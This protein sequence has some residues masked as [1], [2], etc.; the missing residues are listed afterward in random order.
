MSENK[1]YSSF[2]SETEIKNLSVTALSNRPNE[3][4]GQYGKKGLTPE[5]LKA[6][7]SAL[8]EAIAHRLNEVMPELVAY[9]D[10]VKKYADDQITTSNGAVKEYVDGQVD[11]RVEKLTPDVETYPY[12]YVYTVDGK[13]V[14]SLVKTNYGYAPNTIVI[15]NNKGFFV[16]DSPEDDDHPVNKKYFDTKSNN[17]L[18]LD[19]NALE[20]RVANIE[21]GSNGKIYD[22]VELNGAGSALQV[23]EALPYG[24]L[25]RI[26]G[27]VKKIVIG[28]PY[29]LDKDK[30][31]VTKLD[32]DSFMVPGGAMPWFPC[33]VPVGATITAS[34]TSERNTL[35][36][37]SL[38]A[39][40][41]G[42]KQVTGNTVS[43]DSCTPESDAVATKGEVAYIGISRTGTAAEKAEPDT[44]Y[45][46]RV[47]FADP[48]QAT[49][50]TV[51]EEIIIPDEV[52]S[53]EGYGEEGSYLDLTERKFYRDGTAVDVSS[54]LPIESDVIS[55]LPGAI[56]RFT[57]ANEEAVAAA[58][59]FSYKNKIGG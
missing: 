52:T 33:K 8:P 21:Y 36:Y 25:S 9:V 1:K 6:A 48:S 55:L 49:V 58:Y 14:Y 42:S 29:S 56:I 2:M 57:D 59:S 19:H 41:L 22:T 34:Y 10:D 5:Q 3:R 11:T 47:T 50:E 35:R 23:S 51:I 4:S 7:F 27:A 15:R 32:Y 18:Y 53:L 17:S 54:H 20:R 38:F 43:G 31:N 46:L 39:G 37:Y 30:L 16:V 26:G 13:E 24:I 28:L 44:L 12:P 45:N 40:K